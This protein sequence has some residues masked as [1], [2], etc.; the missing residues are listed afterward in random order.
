[1]LLAVL[2]ARAK[3][4]GRV[5]GPNPDKSLKSFPPCYSQS[6]L[7]LCLENSISSNSLNLLRKSSNSHNL[8]RISTVQVL[9]TVKEKGGKHERK[10]YRNFKSEN[11]QDCAQKPQRNCTFMNLASDLSFF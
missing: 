4:R 1:M 3:I 9:Y 6:P 8:L 5:L 7:Q 11:F 2:L 10:P